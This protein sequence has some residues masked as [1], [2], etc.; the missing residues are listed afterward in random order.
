MPLGWILLHV[1]AGPEPGPANSAT[2]ALAED[3]LYMFGFANGT[4]HWYFVE[5]FASGVPDATTL[6]LPENYGKIVDGGHKA[7]WKVPLG[8]DSAVFVAT[9]MATYDLAESKLHRIKDAFARSIL[10]YREAIRFERIRMAFSSGDR[11]EHQTH[12]SPVH[13]TW[14][15]HWGQMSTLLIAWERSG[16]QAW[17]APPFDGIAKTVSGDIHVRNPA[18]AFVKLDFILRPKSKDIFTSLN[19]TTTTYI[20]GPKV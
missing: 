20:S 17:G 14:V 13:A 16:R 2:L 4:D 11:W 8:K 9:T 7:L 1:T 6:P 15:V 3:D 10:M 18:E 19:T 5:K 12:I